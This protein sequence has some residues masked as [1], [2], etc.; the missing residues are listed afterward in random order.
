MTSNKALHDTPHFQHAKGNFGNGAFAVRDPDGRVAVFGL[1]RPELA[2]AL[3]STDSP[4]AKLPG[5]LQHVVVASSNLPPM[6]R[7]YEEDLG[8]LV[9]D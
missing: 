8:F 9:S 1:P 2:G 5:R 6:L 3:S 7:F 4:A